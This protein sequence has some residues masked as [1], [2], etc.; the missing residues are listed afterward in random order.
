MRSAR[1]AAQALSVLLVA[2][3][4]GLLV[5]KV[6]H[7]VGQT[8]IASEVRKGKRPPVPSFSLPQLNASGNLASTSL[9]GKAGVI[10]FWAS[11]CIPCREEAPLLD[12]ASRRWAS[13]GV[14]VLGIDHQDFAGDARRFMRRYGMT[15]PNLVDKG[16]KLYTRFGLTGVPETFCFNR[17]GDVVA[18]VPGAVTRETLD[19]CIRDAL[20]S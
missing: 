16:D 11:W 3:L 15:Y 9:S 14:T 2:G 20:S 5:W 7:Q 6:S 17:A 13:R 10:N 12:D 1:L 8:T 19:Q 18:H 4:L